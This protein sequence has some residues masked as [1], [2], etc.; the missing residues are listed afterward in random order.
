M[1]CRQEGS[2]FDTERTQHACCRS[3]VL[4]VR[5]RLWVPVCGW[6]WQS[7]QTANN[8]CQASSGLHGK[9]PHLDLQCCPVLQQ[10]YAVLQHLLLVL[11]R[12]CSR[13]RGM[14]PC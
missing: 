14:K 2:F 8:R 7:L 9:C 10:E 5:H 1:R 6:L 13:S 12:A 3:P 11:Q 4:C